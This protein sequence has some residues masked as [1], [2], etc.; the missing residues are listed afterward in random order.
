MADRAI[1]GRASLAP[2]RSPHLLAKGRSELANLVTLPYFEL[3]GSEPS[4]PLA[5][6][7]CATFVSFLLEVDP[8]LDPSLDWREKGQRGG[9]AAFWRYL[10]E[11][12]CTQQASASDAFDRGLAGKKVEGFEEAWKAWTAGFPH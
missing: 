1:E 6:A 9:R 11:V 12:Y 4:V 8:P 2:L 5:R 3:I 7:R 10:R